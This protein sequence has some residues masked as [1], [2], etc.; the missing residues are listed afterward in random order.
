MSDRQRIV[1]RYIEGFRNND[2][3][4]ILSCLTNDVVWVLHGYKTLRGKDAFDA[5]I[6]NAEFEG[7]PTLTIER[8]IE[9]SDSVVATGRGSAARRG[10][11]KVD[12]VF[13]DVFDFD[14]DAIDRLETYLVFVTNAS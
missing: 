7:R 4:R 9:E 5:E 6:E 11:E 2:H 14:G 3:A 1:E 12:F 10:G 13:C 8:L